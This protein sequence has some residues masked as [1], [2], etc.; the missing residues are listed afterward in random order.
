MTGKAHPHDD[1]GK[2]LIREIIELSRDSA[3]RRH[4][5]F[6]EDYD[7]SVARYLVQGVD[8]WLN[9]PLR[10]MEA[11]GTSG[12]KAAANAVLNLSIPDGW[13]DEV[14]NDPRNPS[15]IGWAIGKGETY[16]DLN[17][18]N[19]VEADALYDLLERD[20]VPTFYDRG[21]DRIPRRWVE[22]MRAC[23]GSLCHFVNTHRMVRDYFEDYY[24]KAHTQF[25]FLEANGAQRARELSEAVQRI[26]RSWS[27]VCIEKVEDV[28]ADSVTV[29]APMTIRANVHLGSLRPEDVIVELYLGRLDL[30][31]DLVD[32][33]PIPMQA[34]G[35]VGDGTYAYVVT[36]ALSR[37]G[38]H[39][40]TARVRPHHPYMAGKFVP[41]LICW[42][43]ES[44]VAASSAAD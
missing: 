16:T 26:E 2:Q 18:Q 8:V 17:Y 28:L 13:W 12:M 25:R 23:I 35:Q 36:T 3:V 41:G 27:D 33:M 15:S 30:D 34:A 24:T 44:R 11:S 10:P 22:R 39:G 21:A 19:K 42:A 31:G 1:G 14:W 29:A 32:G 9:T 38:L 20:V 43:N 5:V 37:S 6:L 40:F 4:V 7:M